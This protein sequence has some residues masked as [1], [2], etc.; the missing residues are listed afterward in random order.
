MRFWRLLS[1]FLGILILGLWIIRFVLPS[2]IDDVNPLMNCSEEELRMADIF[3]VVPIFENVSIGEDEGWC[4]YVLSL[5]K[6]L[7]LHGV[8]H[9]YREFGVYRDEEY[10]KKGVGVFEECFGVDPAGLKPPQIYWDKENDWIK[11]EFE[12]DLFWNQVFHKVYH[13]GDSGVF[14]NWLIR[15]F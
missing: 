8:Y 5:D 14:P 15:I 12:V 6:K 7:A 3:Y 4:D 13:C 1:V 2:Q 9:E 11:D 10:L